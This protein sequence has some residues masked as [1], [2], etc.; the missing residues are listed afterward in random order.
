MLAM[1]SAHR[2]K[3]VAVTVFLLALSATLAFVL[4]KKPVYR[5]YTTILAQRSS[6]LPSAARAMFE[7]LP[8]RSAWEVVHRRENLVALVKATNL[9]GSAPFPDDVDLRTRIKRALGLGKTTDA[10][11]DP[12]D[13]LV[14]VLDKE[15]EVTTDEGT[16]T[17]KLDWPDPRQAHS[18]VQAALQNFLEARHLQEVT[19]I[20]EIISVLRGRAAVLRKNLDDVMAD[21]Q[22]RRPVV[23]RAPSG[24][25]A[26]QPSEELVRLQSLLASKQRAIEDVENFRR[27]RIAD[28]DAQLQQALNAFS[29]AHPTVIALR[30]EYAAVSR[31]SPQIATL[32]EEELKL[33]AQVSA[34]AAREGTSATPT[35]A[36]APALDTLRTSED[37]RVI[38]ARAQYEQLNARLGAAQVELDAARAAFKYRYN[39][40]WPPQVPDAPYG[41]SRVEIALAGLIASFCAAIFAAAIPDVVRGRILQRWQVERSLDL[42]VL[43]EIRRK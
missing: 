40:V 7:E 2:R 17:I 41:N 15:L 43:G 3:T 26:P 38:E 16:I 39:V 14:L 4:T 12:V 20:D 6:A 35:A 9:A 36:P 21:V 10:A 31:E 22:R 24:A 28:V 37:P 19:A 11:L 25:L 30:Q 13:R 27:R 29:D 33:R 18:I 42:P 32:R 34:R 23:A 8:T 1:N 5:V